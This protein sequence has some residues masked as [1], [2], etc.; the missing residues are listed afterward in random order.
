LTHGFLPREGGDDAAGPPGE[1]VAGRERPERGLEAAAGRGRGAR[2]AQG[3]GGGGER[4]ERGAGGLAGGRSGGVEEGGGHRGRA[5]VVARPRGCAR[6]LGKGGGDGRERARWSGG[7]EMRGGGGGGG[8]RAADGT[9]GGR[10]SGR[11]SGENRG[12]F[13]GF[14]GGFWPIFGGSEALARAARGVFVALRGGSAIG[15]PALQPR[16]GSVAFRFAFHARSTFRSRS[17]PVMSNSGELAG[18]LPS[19]THLR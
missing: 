18:E 17:P 13:V 8:G 16:E 7:R 3:H 1:A 11:W 2:E 15:R 9:K 19:A 12:S 4:V 10:M 14:L 5:V 6:R